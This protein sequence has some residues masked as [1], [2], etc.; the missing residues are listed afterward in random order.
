MQFQADHITLDGA[1][2]M[3]SPSPSGD[4]FIFSGRN[5][6]G[7]LTSFTNSSTVGTSG[8]N[9][10]Q[11]S[12]S[13]ARWIIWAADI[14]SSGFSPGALPYDFTLYG[15]ASPSDWSAI[16]GNGYISTAAGV[17]TVTGTIVPKV[18]D[19]TLSVPLQSALQASGRAARTASSARRRAC[20][21]RPRLSARASRSS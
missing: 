3:V 19:A 20:S 1:T 17:A 11:T 5:G 16:A 12:G 8:S 6:T 2:S 7:P 21:T 15:A 18:Y 4:I 9:A 13:P 14:T 10:L